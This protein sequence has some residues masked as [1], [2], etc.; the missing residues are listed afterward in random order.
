MLT[1]A[2]AP[3]LCPSPRSAIPEAHSSISLDLGE[4]FPMVVKEG[5]KPGRCGQHGCVFWTDRQRGDKA[6]DTLQNPPQEGDTVRHYARA[7]G[8][9][10]EQPETRY[11]TLLPS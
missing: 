2:E 9:K 7:S 5:Q 3:L 1:E 6:D 11:T 8:G 10:Y 4:R